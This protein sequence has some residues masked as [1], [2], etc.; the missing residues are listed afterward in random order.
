MK[1]K[2]LIFLGLSLCL[3]AQDKTEVPPETVVA[4][5]NGR[6]VTADEIQKMV[7]ALPAPVQKAFINDPEQF[8]K[9]HAWYELQAATAV[10]D[11]LHEQ[12]P[13]K[14]TLAFQRM[15]T[16][17]QAEWND[18]HSK[19][20]VTPQQQKEFYD[21]N[22]NKYLEVQ[23]KVIYIPFTSSTNEE[24]AK[25]T[26]Q[27]V[28]QQARGGVD[29]VK[30]VKEYSKDSASASQ[31]GD[32]GLPVRA[33]TKQIPEPMRNAVLALKAGQVSDPLRHQNGY[34]VFRAESAGVQPFEKVKD[35]IYVELKDIG[36]N[37]WKEKTKAASKVQ[38]TNEAFFQS[39]KQKAQQQ[40]Q[41]QQAQP[42]Q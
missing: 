17:V 16:L 38:F 8:M 20:L 22:Q 33:S 12:S 42:K 35:E 21:K 6:K 19:I 36:F 13:W 26:A 18:A 11:R 28:V 24:E 41:Q 34:Y 30:L 10:E 9:E 14:E 27:K 15:M 25:T 40:Q 5:V 29:F 32:L 4:V 7:A 37:E 39:V 23:T 3:F 31:N 1:R 2:C